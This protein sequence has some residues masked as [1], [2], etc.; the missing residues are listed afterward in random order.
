MLDRALAL[1]LFLGVM[2]LIDRTR[3]PCLI[4]SCVFAEAGVVARSTVSY[5]RS[6]ESHRS[7]RQRL[8][9]ATPSAPPPK[10]PPAHIRRIAVNE[11][12]VLLPQV[13]KLLASLDGAK[14]KKQ[15]VS[16]RDTVLCYGVAIVDTHDL[17][18][19]DG[20]APDLTVTLDG[21]GI[22]AYAAL[23]LL[24]LQVIGRIFGTDH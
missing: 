17:F 4:F 7:K 10:F 15:A 22:S 1:T 24:E 19:L 5:T 11:N 14:L 3:P 21:F 20:C 8:E 23:A 2:M 16:G 6:Y 18:Y 13:K 12:G 9:L